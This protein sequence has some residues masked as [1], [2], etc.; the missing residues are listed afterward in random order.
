[1]VSFGAVCVE[2]ERD[3]KSMGNIITVLDGNQTVL[4][5]VDGIGAYD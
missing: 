1:M 2:P 3:K 5:G 4:G